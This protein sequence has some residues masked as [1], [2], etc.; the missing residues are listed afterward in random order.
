MPIES[1]C[2]V[3]YLVLHAL[4][5]NTNKKHAYRN[6]STSLAQHILFLYI[7][8]KYA[9]K[10]LSALLVH[11]LHFYMLLD[12]MPIGFEH[13]WLFSQFALLPGFRYHSYW[14]VLNNKDLLLLILI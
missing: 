11:M 4:F 1:K 8:R 5:L 2:F 14:I 9:Y 12:S 10:N 6:P 7:I 13:H 3:C